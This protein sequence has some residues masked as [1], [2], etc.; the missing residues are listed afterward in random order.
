MRDI[1]R[2]MVMVMLLALSLTIIIAVSAL[3]PTVAVAKHKNGNTKREYINCY[4]D[5]WF[6]NNINI[7]F[8]NIKLHIDII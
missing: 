5:T 2:K 1:E 4:L 8:K 6:Y 7:I 3:A